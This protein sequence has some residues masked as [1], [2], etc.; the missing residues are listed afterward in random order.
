MHCTTRRSGAVRTVWAI[1]TVL[2]S[3]ALA[4]T[5]ARADDAI[6]GVQ[7]VAIDQPRIFMT[8]RRAPDQPVLSTKIDGEGV[9]AIEAFLDTGASGVVLSKQT[10][11]A[12]GVQSET[13]LDGKRVTFEDVGVGGSETF[14]VSEPLRVALAPYSSVTD[15]TNLG[16][17]GAPSDA[18]R[19][20]IRPAGGFLEMLVG[21]L[22][23]AGMPAMSGKVVVIDARPA[24]TFM[25]KLKTS[26]HEPDD[27]H[28]PK[29]T[30]KIPLTYVSFER[31]TRTVPSDATPPTVVPNP[32]IGPSPLTRDNTNPPIVLGHKGESARITMLLDT[33]APVSMISESVANQLGVR[34]SHDRST[35]EGVA[36]EGQFE[37]TVT[38]IGGNK[39]ARGFFVDVMQVPTT[40]GRAIKYLKAPVLVNDITVVDPKNG[41]PLTLEGVFGMNFLVASAQVSGGLLPDIGQLTQGAFT[42][43]VIDHPRRTLGVQ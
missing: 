3:L 41:K 25:D 14:H 23:V 33:G 36:P 42:T 7:P 22:D 16:A 17:Y 1:G 19:M 8:L 30:R 34:Y 40:D 11:E 18:I 6:E 15:G 13:T 35:L 37:L 26:V 21:G 2:L 29:V 10:A 24:N 27:P 20:Q 43:I 4:L 38:G 28:I 39:T 31:F 9:F 32:M 5:T 12:L